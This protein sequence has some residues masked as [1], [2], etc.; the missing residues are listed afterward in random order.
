MKVIRGVNHVIFWR[1]VCFGR[2]LRRAKKGRITK[3]GEKELRKLRRDDLS[4]NK[5]WKILMGREVEEKKLQKV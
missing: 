4:V 3:L 1:G 5:S 2:A